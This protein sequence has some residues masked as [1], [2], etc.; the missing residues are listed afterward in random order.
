VS[1]WLIYMNFGTV[2]IVLTGIKTERMWFRVLLGIVG[3]AYWV[4]AVG[5]MFS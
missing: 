1:D 3:V 5:A 2:F 4:A